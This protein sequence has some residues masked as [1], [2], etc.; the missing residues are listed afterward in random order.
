M[1]F[2]VAPAGFLGMADTKNTGLY[3]VLLISLLW[4]LLFTMYFYKEF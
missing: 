2:D 3:P 4:S 1:Q